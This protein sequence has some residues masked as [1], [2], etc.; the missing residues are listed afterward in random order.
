MAVVA[1]LVAIA[2][3]LVVCAAEKVFFVEDFE[4]A[5]ETPWGTL[6]AGW[7]I[8]GETAGARARVEHGRLLVDA[9]AAGLPGATVWLDRELPADVEVSFEVHVV[10]S[11]NDANNMNLL[12]QFRD[13]RGTSLR[14]TR[15]ER[16]DGRYARYHSERLQGTILTFLANGN[17]DEARL[18]VRQVPPFD[19]VVQEHVGH[20]ARKRTTYRVEVS[21]R[22][23]RFIVCVRP[24]PPCV[25]LIRTR[26]VTESDAHGHRP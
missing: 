6:P 18:R 23:D 13:S 21:R 24:R 12:F 7:W 20:H 11:I 26:C 9:T 17:P 19:P 25:S 3:G 14:E 10:D 2:E 22:G 4:T 16:A 1:T 8:E 15:A 5:P